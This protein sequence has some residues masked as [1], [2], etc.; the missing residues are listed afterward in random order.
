VRATHF[1]ANKLRFSLP[2]RPALRLETLILVIAAFLV[3][4][5]NAS[6]WRNIIAGRSWSE[7]SN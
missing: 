5:A 4:T 7:P 6:W 2:R 1:I 3:V